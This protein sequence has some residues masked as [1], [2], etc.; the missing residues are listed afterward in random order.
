MD[1][2]LAGP[3]TASRAFVVGPRA[4]WASPT[5]AGNRVGADLPVRQRA[6]R[7]VSRAAHPT[8]RS[9]GVA[10]TREADARRGCSARCASSSDGPRRV[11][12]RARRAP[13]RLRRREG[14]QTGPPSAARRASVRAVATGATGSGSSRRRRG[15]LRWPSSVRRRPRR[16]GQPLGVAQQALGAAP[17]ARAAPG[18]AGR[19]AT[20]S[21]SADLQAVLRRRDG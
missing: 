20:S 7:R 8:S 18:S 1:D 5:C 21:R 2:G 3:R 4:R 16:D 12:R 9:A 10:W 19:S 6:M 15:W 11:R 13:R 17:T 14:R